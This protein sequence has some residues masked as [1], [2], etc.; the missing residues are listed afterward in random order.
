MQNTI[1]MEEKMVR[2]KEAS[3]IL[4]KSISTITRH[5]AAGDFRSDFEKRYIVVNI[6]DA[7]RYYQERESRKISN[8]PAE[9]WREYRL[10][11]KQNNK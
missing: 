11:R 8:R 6:N 9:Y 3:K 2:L 10:K 7:L 4:N 5:I 1:E